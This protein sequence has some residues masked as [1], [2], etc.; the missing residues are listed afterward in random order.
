MSK[1]VRQFSWKLPKPAKTCAI[2]RYG[3]IGDNLMA[4]SILPSLKE[5][6][7]WIDFYCQTGPGYEAIKHDPHVDRFIL[8]G[9]DEIPPQLLKEFWDETMT[10]YD[11][12]INLCESVETSLLAAPGRTPFEW[13]NLVRAKM[14]DRNYLEFTHEVA[15]VPPP[16]RPK[17]YSTVDER[18]WARKTAQQWGRKNIL[19]SLSGS[20]GHKVWPHIDPVIAQIMLEWDD[21]HVVFVGDEFCKILE[22]PWE[23][24]RR[25]HLKSGKWTI[26]QTLAFAEVADLVIGTETG[27]L[28]GAGC[29]DTP[30]II[31][32]SH[33]SEEMLT[34]HWTNVTVLKQPEGVGCPKRWAEN[35]GACRML[36]GANGADPWLACPQ[37]PSTGTAMCQFHISPE[38]MWLAVEDALTHQVRKAA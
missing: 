24:E 33:S 38:K 9:K 7:Y 30:K 18:A 13:P 15:G 35:G 19:W 27:V 21:V 11:K 8:Q 29:M 31:T 26:R 32:L 22:L 10:R 4:S 14:M 17:F 1:Y 20:S 12:W 25:C 6:G 28:N 34:K 36:H 16:Y 2:V 5:Q 3:A 37:E 23:K